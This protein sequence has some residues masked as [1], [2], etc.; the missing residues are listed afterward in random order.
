MNEN[1]IISIV[2][3]CF[4]EEEVIEI[5]LEQ[6]EPIL[7][8]TKQ[9]YEII[10]INDGSTDNTFAIL[11]NAKNNHKNI[12]ILNL[13]RNF[14]KEAALTAG[15]DSALGEVVIPIDVDLQHPPEL[16]PL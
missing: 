8:S 11:L 14:G 3:P 4:N 2:C 7:E 5:F 10:F 1:P 13:S 16:I 9:S 6:I 12:R 15:L